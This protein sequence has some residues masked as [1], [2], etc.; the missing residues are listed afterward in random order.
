MNPYLA[1]HGDGG[2]ATV[3]PWFGVLRGSNMEYVWSTYFDD[4]YVMDVLNALLAE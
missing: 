1:A 3:T 2:I 4:S